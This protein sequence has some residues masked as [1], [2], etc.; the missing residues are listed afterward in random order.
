MFSLSPGTP[1]TQ[2]AQPAHQ[3][4]DAARRLRLARYSASI[5]C[6]SAMEFI[7]AVMCPRAEGHLVLDQVDQLVAHLAWRD[8]QRLELDRVRL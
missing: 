2:A 8:E 6:G 5:I 1:G 4:V 3:Q 7:L